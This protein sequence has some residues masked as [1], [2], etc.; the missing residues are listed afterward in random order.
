MFYTIIIIIFLYNSSNIRID[1]IYLLNYGR[2]FYL[3]IF[4]LNAIEWT[5]ATYLFHKYYPHIQ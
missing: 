1:N 4:S 5:Y 3:C 2:V